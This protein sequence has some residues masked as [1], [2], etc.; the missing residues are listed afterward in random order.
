[1]CP[2]PCSPSTAISGD[3]SLA[4]ASS[5]PLLEAAKPGGLL[6]SLAARCKA[7]YLAS[8]HIRKEPGLSPGV[9]LSLVLNLE[10]DLLAAPRTDQQAV[11]ALLPPGAVPVHLG[12]SH[13]YPE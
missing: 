2:Q 3:N 11:S 13:R 6:S 1:M 7:W 9:R 4:S 10:E 12:P 5:S 8:G